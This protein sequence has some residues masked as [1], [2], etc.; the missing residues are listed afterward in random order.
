MSSNQVPNTLPFTLL[1]WSSKSSDFNSNPIPLDANKT[2][3]ITIHVAASSNLK[4]VAQIQASQDGSTW[5]DLSGASQFINDDG[6]YLF[7]LTDIQSI[8]FLRVSMKITQGSALFIMS[9]RNS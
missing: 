1:D 5:M 2:S 6:D 3:C 9:A 7:N 8:M 4:C